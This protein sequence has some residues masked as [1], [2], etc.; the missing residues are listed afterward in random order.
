MS[1]EIHE[2]ILELIGGTPMIRLRK[3]PDPG[4][5]DVLVKV[6]Y[7]NPGGSIKD[8]IAADIIEDAERRG[9]LKPG[10][11]IV[12]GTSGNTGLG[13]AMA[14]AVKGYRCIIVVTDKQSR[15]K[16]R[17][18]KAFGAEVVIVPASAA[19]GS[20]ENY[21]NTARRIA[22]EIPG[23]LLAD[24]FSNPVNVRTH[25]TRTGEEIWRQ[26]AGNIDV[27][28]AGIG[29]GGTITGIAHRLREKNPEIRIVGADP[30]G[31]VFRE[32]KETGTFTEH[33]SY[34]VEGIGGDMIPDILDLGCIDE[35]ITVPDSDSFTMSRRLAR[36]E[37]I[38][39][40]GS[41]GALVHAALQVARELPKD[42]VVVTLIPDTGERYLSTFYSDEWMKD[43]GLSAD[44]G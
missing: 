19:P 34:L 18:L 22:G 4:G 26:T 2:S 39:G 9:A 31:S 44:S 42:K 43:Q 3:L 38:L 23:S 29:T 13:L 20:P 27:F 30:H 32:Y 25:Y 28:V 10:G 33:H 36:E 41:A 17:L 7:F 14:A 40:G 16:I 35:I 1:T 12:E 24:Q 15:E 37:G 21:I 6:E 8:R 11:T 5:A